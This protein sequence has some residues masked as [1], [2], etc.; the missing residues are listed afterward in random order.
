VPAAA[1]PVNPACTECRGKGCNFCAQGAPGAV[2]AS[3]AAVETIPTA[4]FPPG[5]G[6]N[7]YSLGAATSRRDP[8]ERFSW[9]SLPQQY[10]QVR[11]LFPCVQATPLEGRPG[12]FR[13][14]LAFHI[15]QKTITRGRIGSPL[16]TPKAAGMALPQH[17]G[18]ASG[19]LLHTRNLRPHPA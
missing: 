16:G 4:V 12:A 3:Y 6:G 5:G 15:T 14:T 7:S 11:A 9:A 13:L 1:V 19:S 10:K 2:P 8:W 18:N 17:P